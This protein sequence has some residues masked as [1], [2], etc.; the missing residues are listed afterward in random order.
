MKQK[1]LS[2]FFSLLGSSNLVR[3]GGYTPHGQY[4]NKMERF[5]DVDMNESH[6][7]L[8]FWW[9]PHHRTLL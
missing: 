9:A 3:L 4:I 6:T 8:K 7:C 5:D 1:K 2:I